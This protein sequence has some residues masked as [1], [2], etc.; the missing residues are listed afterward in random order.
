VY[1][2]LFIQLLAFTGIVCLNIFIPQL[3]AFNT[4]YLYVALVIGIFAIIVYCIM[5]AVRQI[6]PLNLLALSCWTL[7]V[8]WPV[9][10]VCSA[11]QINAVL[12]TLGLTLLIL[13]CLTVVVCITQ[14]RLQWLAVGLCMGMCLMLVGSLVTGIMALV[15][16]VPLW[17]HYII[18]SF[19]ALLFSVFIM[20]DTSNIIHTHRYS[21]WIQGA[22][23]LY[24]DTI[25]LFSFML[26][27]VGSARR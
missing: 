21:E 13:A 7:L 4:R 12:L 22:A 1:S 10:M 9:G 6:F 19:G 25:N 11:Y 20:Y 24:L 2:I 23:A 3:V 14:A 8:S 18:A 27:L 16:G 15:V 26:R 5:F 17:W